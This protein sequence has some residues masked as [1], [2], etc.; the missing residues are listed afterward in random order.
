MTHAI[1]LKR[2]LDAQSDC[3]ERVKAEMTEGHKQS[4]WIW[5]I[6]P[7]IEIKKAGVSPYHIQ[8]AIHSL[9]EAKAYLD[10]R[11]LGKRLIELS[12][13]VLTHPDIPINDIMGWSLD[14]MKFKSSMSLFSLVSPEGSVFHRVLDQFFEGKR[15][16][17][18]LKKFNIPFNE[19]EQQE[20]EEEEKKQQEKPKAESGGLFSFFRAKKP[21]EK[22]EPARAAPKRVKS[23]TAGCTGAHTVESKP[24]AK[25]DDDA[26]KPVAKSDD[27]KTKPPPRDE[28]KSAG[29]DVQPPSKSAG[30]AAGPE[31][32]PPNPADKGAPESAPDETPRE[33]KE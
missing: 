2:F 18:T 23:D 12:E 26:S 9:E 11:V 15:C 19:K 5:Y 17:L 8:Y 4:C 13:I 20:A 10:H 3:Y 30:E 7:Q 22:E 29:K 21:I 25:S 32:E 6:F 28:A 31:P 16:R 1:D 14:A 27:G 24:A 33:V